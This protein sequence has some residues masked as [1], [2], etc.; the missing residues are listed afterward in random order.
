[1]TKTEKIA[2]QM[3]KALEDCGWIVLAVEVK[4]LCTF[5]YTT[6]SV[7]FRITTNNSE[8]VYDEDGKVERGW[9]EWQTNGNVKIRLPR[10]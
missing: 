4:E 1:M 6:Y 8:T 5:K 9:F 2:K 3:T 7:K 10:L